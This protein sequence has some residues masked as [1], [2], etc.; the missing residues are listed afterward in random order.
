MIQSRN[1]LI[2]ADRSLT[3]ERVVPEPG[4]FLVG[5]RLT[6]ADLAV[7]S[8][9]ANFAH[10]KCQKEEGRHDRV[11]AY[12]DSILARPSFAPWIERESAVLAK[13]AA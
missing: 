8:P 3:L 10:L 1:S 9:F 7:A 4:A 6:L 13:F 2:R 5:D 11:Y 12:V